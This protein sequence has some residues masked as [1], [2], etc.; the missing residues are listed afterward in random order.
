MENNQWSTKNRRE[1]EN[2]YITQS[3]RSC[4]MYGFEVLD[5]KHLKTMRDALMSLRRVKVN[6]SPPE[7]AGACD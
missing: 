3:G 7:E 6:D 1:K 5:I 2:V 4:N